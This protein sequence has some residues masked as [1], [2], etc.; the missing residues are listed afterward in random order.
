MGR[1]VQYNDW[2]DE[3]CGNFAREGLRTLVIARK[4]L[5]DVAYNDFQESYQSSYCFMLFLM[6]LVQES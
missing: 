3:E 2:L 5:S 4:R 6:P 1:I